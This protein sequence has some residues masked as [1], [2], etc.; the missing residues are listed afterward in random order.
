MRNVSV[1]MYCVNKKEQSFHYSLAALISLNS[2]TDL[3][4]DKSDKIM[5][6]SQT[7]CLHRN[8]PLRD[9][10]HDGLKQLSQNDCIPD[11]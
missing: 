5:V 8:Q 6:T 10:S 4:L 11:K 9:G 7:F 2:M 1:M 3:G